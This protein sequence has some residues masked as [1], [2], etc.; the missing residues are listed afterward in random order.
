MAQDPS[1][2]QVE[3]P[4]QS[5]EPTLDKPAAPP[6]QPTWMV[7]CMSTQA[8]FD[9]GASQAFFAKET[10]QRLL[11]M[12]VRVPPKPMTPPCCFSCPSASICQ[13]GSRCSSARRRQLRR[14]RYRVAIKMAAWPNMTSV[15]GRSLPC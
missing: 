13:R 5:A 7:N 15:T 3:N 14:L 1:Q 8:G 11:S 10:G 9:C 6:A 12:A 2:S 4:Q